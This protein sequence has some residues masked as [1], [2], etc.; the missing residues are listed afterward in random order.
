MKT[1]RTI[2][3]DDESLALDLLRA[4]LSRYPQVEIIAECQNGRQAIAKANELQP[5]LMFLD[6][7]MPELT[8]FDVIKNIQADIMPLVV[9]VTAY[10][11]YAL[12]A[13]D[14]Y[15][16][17]YLLKPLDQDLL[18]RAL[19]RCQ[20]RLVVNGASNKSEI[21][22]A[23]HKISDGNTGVSSSNLHKASSVQ[24]A[25]LSAPQEWKKII[26]KDRDAINLINQEK[27]R[28]GRCCGRLHVYSYWW[29]NT[30]YAQHSQI[31]ARP[32][33]P[34]T[35]SK[36]SPINNCESYA[37]P[38]NHSVRERRIFLRTRQQ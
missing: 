33:K 1:I 21:I 15:A 2:I 37:H 31:T 35:V 28:L 22:E 17:D 5:D 18:E 19:S 26:I 7:Q 36:S 13:F 10:D 25:E 16:V 27:H 12:E 38:K 3:V 6:I 11:H 32:T 4:Y 30:H 14:V 20:S 9:F 23:L 8:G 24:S 34:T 29:A